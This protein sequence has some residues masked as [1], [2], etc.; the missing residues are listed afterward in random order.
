MSKQS[1]YDFGFRALKSVLRSAGNVKRQVQREITEA[2]RDSSGGD[3]GADDASDK[4]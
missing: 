4:W 1:H 3:A 2:A